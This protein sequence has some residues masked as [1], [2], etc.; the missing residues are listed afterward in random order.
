MNDSQAKPLRNSSRTLAKV[1]VAVLVVIA[2]AG[3]VL[4]TLRGRGTPADTSV[5]ADATQP[6]ASAMTEVDPAAALEA[7]AGPNRVVF[8]PRSDKLSAP[9]T[10][11]LQHIAENAH[12]ENRAMVV[13]GKIESRPDQADQMALAQKRA[14]AVRQA[15]AANGVPLAAIN[16]EIALLPAG[17]VS[18][19]DADR[20]DIA[21]R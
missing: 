17:G 20:F 3:I 8:A 11:K 5:A 15:L 12:S 21:F 7:A 14:Q 4:A 10:A 9:A 1:A 6:A 18:A 13:R 19:S 16:I 2:V